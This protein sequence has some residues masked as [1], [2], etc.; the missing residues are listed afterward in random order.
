MHN[1]MF[2]VDFFLTSSDCCKYMCIDRGIGIHW[3]YFYDSNN[4]NDDDGSDDDGKNGNRVLTISW[5]SEILEQI[6][7]ISDLKSASVVVIVVAVTV[8]AITIPLLY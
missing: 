3:Y 4:C 6:F 8:V 7:L 2:I 1:S 5:K